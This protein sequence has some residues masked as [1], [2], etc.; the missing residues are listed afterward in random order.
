LRIE[1]WFLVAIAVLLAGCSDPAPPPG[2]SP[3][4]SASRETEARVAD[5]LAPR[6]VVHPS[7]KESFVNPGLVV[8]DGGRLHMLTNSFT[9]YP[10]ASFVS[11]LTS[12]DGI[13]WEPGASGP[14]LRNTQVPDA[15]ETFTTAF[16]T[17]GYQAEDGSWVAYGYTFE[18]QFTDGFI[19]RSTAPRLEGP[20]RVDRRPAIGPGAEGTW[21]S[22]RVA[23]PSL[24]RS[25]DGLLLFY[26]GFDEDGIGRIGVATS[27]D[28]VT[29][30][31]GDGPVFEGAQEWDGGS[32]GNPQVVSTA[33]GLLMVYRT[34]AAGGFGFG[35]ARSAD[36]ASWVPSDA[37]PIMD[38]DRSPNGAQLWQSEAVMVGGELRWWLEV[39]FGS[40]TT[41]LYAYR[42]DTDAA[43]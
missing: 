16:V 30:S 42:L 6:A 23:E 13:A 25:D 11:H 27:T 3:S 17:T 18:G 34:E 36:G 4:P 9:R 5:L 37:N 38:E 15:H 1:R 40:G 39:G 24:V 35:L 10:G 33:D 7:G 12:S 26:T 28:G 8:E 31:R 41:N 2:P 32:V 21:D 20:W 29:W 22:L 14:V 43:W 19:W